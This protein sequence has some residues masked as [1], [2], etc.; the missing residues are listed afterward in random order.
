L[1]RVSER[2]KM[3]NT[4]KLKDECGVFGIYEPGCTNIST[5][6]YFGLIALQHRGQE[7]AG[8]AVLNDGNV[9][10]YYKDMGLVQEVF[11][12]T[13]LETLK[14]DISVGHVR[15]STTGESYLANAQPLVVQY[16][17]GSIALAHNG[18]LINADKLR[19][20]IENSGGVFQTS[21]D[22][23]VIAALIAR[24]YKG[25]IIEAVKSTVTTVKG[26]FSLVIACEGKLI[27]LRDPYG[28][29]PLVLGKMKSGGYVLSSETSGLDVVEA[30]LI[31]DIKAGE[32]VVIDENGVDFIVYAQ[33]CKKSLCSFE[34]VYF[35]RPDSIIE[36]KNVYMSRR[37]AGKILAKEHPASADMV[38]AVPDSGNAAAVGYA[39]E[40]GIPYGVG[41]IKNKYLGRT[42]I[43]PDQKSRELAVKLKLNVLK[44]NV[45]GKRIVLIDDSIVRG[46]TSKKIVSMLREAGAK[47]VHMRVCSPPV[48]FS[49]Y[50]G[51]DTPEK[52]HLIGSEM[53]V[54]EIGKLIGLDSLGYLSIDG[55]LQ[56]IGL[57]K[58][59]MCS[60]CFSGD[61]PMEVPKLG[62]K[63]VFEK[64]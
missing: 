30:E 17:G 26:A 3:L 54:E 6:T 34:F 28:I 59:S 8:I 45:K 12:S 20:E 52:K 29:R 49:C 5:L 35:A 10:K 38:I 64:V 24:N 36:S 19:D 48:K 16:K 42:F 32:M 58:D 53:S 23:E 1:K 22:S 57:L 44:E 55:L 31:R 56:S 60:A 43:Q 14:G 15:Y 46:T 41:L 50:F 37:C 47:E 2:V 63:Y 39:E 61:Y 13:I 27:G 11:N 18:N 40:S 33:G 25:N 7:S 21:I 62:N 4:D 9:I 51:I